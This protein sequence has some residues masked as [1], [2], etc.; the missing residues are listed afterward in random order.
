MKNKLLASFLALVSLLASSAH[1]CNR[2]DTSRKGS[3]YPL[4]NLSPYQEI[5]GAL[6]VTDGCS[7]K[8]DNFTY[9]PAAIQTYF[10]AYNSF[11][12]DD[13]GYRLV[14]GAQGAY[15]Q[16]NA[17][18]TIRDEVESFAA[19]KVIRILSEF[20]NTVF[21]EAYL[22]SASTEGAMGPASAS[23]TSTSGGALASMMMASWV[24]GVAVL[25]FTML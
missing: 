21:A 6:T 13:K 16:F 8:I 18:F 22:D 2:N 25:G 20:N 10:Y 12:P 5:D 14:K 15:W 11:A 17:T 7:F 1:A 9:Y 19:I 4:K 3:S 23:G 24:L